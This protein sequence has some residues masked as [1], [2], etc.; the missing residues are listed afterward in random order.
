VKPERADGTKLRP[1]VLPPH[2]VRP[3]SN[4]LT[5]HVVPRRSLPLV[6]V[7]LVVR[8]GSAFDLPGQHGVSDFASRLLRR[9]A[10]GLSADEISETVELVGASVGGYANEENVVLSVSTPSKHLDAMLGVLAQLVL[11]PDF[12]EPEV[13]LARRRTLAQLAN[14]L[15]DPGTL[16]DRALSRAV[17][18]RHPYA[19]E[20]SGGK[21]DVER[22]TRAQLKAF[23]QER[24]GPKVSHLYVVGDADVEHVSRVIERTLG[25]WGGGPSFA[26]EVP[27]WTGLE[28]PGEV[29]IV[30][31]PE[32]TQAQVRI[33]AAGVKRGHPDHFPLV[34]FNAVLGGG[35]TSRLVT[36]IRVKRGLSYGAGSSFDML[37]AG[38][39]FTV[40]SFT[41][42]DNVPTLLDVALGEVEKMRVKGPT[43]R[44]LATV[45]RYICG[46]YPGRL[47]T[48]E[49]VAGAIADVVHYG[50]PA[51][52]ISGYRERISA[53]TVKQAAE[54][55]RK[56]LFT[57][58]RVVALV[59]NAEAL[60]P[61][62]SR[63]GPITV[64]R[65]AD[66]E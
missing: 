11:E 21:A 9:G 57:T 4:G 1:L 32:Q 59:G 48:N 18:G 35:F 51:D 3:L 53:V 23:H 49:A 64:L 2:D 17:W 10:A 31:K 43:P 39:A 54:A 63:Y 20:S 7:R 28:K 13:E 52:W 29:V 66:L 65:P 25:G 27:T 33:G 34:A 58:E 61:E 30:D 8:A 41:R 62:V 45:Q 44:E 37:S 6:A 50:L 60:K 55:A 42:T 24:M 36:E 12:P 16:A 38:G 14:E 40:S 56:H 26:P 5:L 15:D 19:W 22:I 47:E 46:L